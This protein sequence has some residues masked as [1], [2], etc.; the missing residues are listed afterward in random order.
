MNRFR[1]AVLAASLIVMAGLPACR[2]VNG[3][4]REEAANR[5]AVPSNMLKRQISADPFMITVFERVYKEGEPATIY[6][7]G[8]GV[9]WMTRTIPSLNPTPD[10]PVAL[11]L[12]TRDLSP[13]VIYVARP[14]QFS[15]LIAENTPCPQTYWTDGR[16]SV[17]AMDA[18][19]TVLDKLKAAHRLSG[20]NL[21]GYS[22]GGAVAALLAA[23]RKD[24]LSL[25]TVAGNLDHEVLNANHNV[26]PM[27]N[28]LN[29]RDFAKDI[30]NIPQHHFIGAWDDVVDH[31]V[32]D[33]FRSAMGDSHCVR[34]SVVDEV[35]HEKGWVNRWPSLLQQPLDCNVA[36]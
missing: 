9:A 29:P 32:Y 22:G 4:W 8:D 1:I 21:V 34:M 31:S 24:V 33:S 19:N 18:M 35:D 10:Y 25:R 27:S 15:G 3:Y 36:P 17:T 5:L 23:K 30:A 6:I 20:F 13:N 28:S 2:T 14:C 12:A 26:S 16:F 11:H 7:E